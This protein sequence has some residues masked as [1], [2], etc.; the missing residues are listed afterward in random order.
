HTITMTGKNEEIK[1]I[2]PKNFIEINPLTA[3]KYLIKQGDSVIVSS[4][5]GE[6]SAEAHVTDKIGEDIIFMPFHFADGAN[7]L[8]NT[9]LDETCN[10]PE[11]KVCAIAITKQ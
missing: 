6:T 4:R 5:R 1:Q 11:L 9:V 3:K 7:M 8:T 10:I 2:V